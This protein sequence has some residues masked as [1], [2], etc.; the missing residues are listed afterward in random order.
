MNISQVKKNHCEPQIP[1]EKK[2]FIKIL[3]IQTEKKNP[4]SYKMKLSP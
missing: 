1:P 4:D 3:E 2:S